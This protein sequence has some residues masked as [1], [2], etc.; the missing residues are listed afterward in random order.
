MIFNQEKDNY[1]DIFTIED[2]TNAVIAG[3]FITDDGVGYYGT[4]THYSYECGV[5]HYGI[6][7][8][9]QQGATHVH[10]FNK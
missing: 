2:F 3:A 6:P 5:W 7:N 9:I 1:G 4:E 10:W 8:A